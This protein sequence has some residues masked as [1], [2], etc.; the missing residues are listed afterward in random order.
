MFVHGHYFQVGNCNST[1][2]DQAHPKELGAAWIV[3]IRS[4]GWT[5]MQPCSL[6]QGAILDESVLYGSCESDGFGNVDC[7]TWVSIVL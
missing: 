7:W 6:R 3:D 5:A 1:Q 4:I 2:L